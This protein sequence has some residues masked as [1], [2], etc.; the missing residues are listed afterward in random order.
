MKKTLLNLVIFLSLAKIGYAQ[1][2]KFIKGS[3]D[4]LGNRIGFHIQFLDSRFLVCD[5]NNA[6]YKQ[7]VYFINDKPLKY[8]ALPP[9]FIKH[10][11]LNGP[12][13][14]NAK[15]SI[16]LLD[17]WYSFSHKRKADSLEFLYKDGYLLYEKLVTRN[18]KPTILIPSFK[19][20][21]NYEYY[22]EERFFNKWFDDQFPSYYFQCFI[23]PENKKP[24]NKEMLYIYYDG[25]KWQE[26]SDKQ[27]E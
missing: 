26:V 27:T 17:G 21:P 8:Y 3:I 25:N 2:E 7:Y 14:K 19:A 1:S 4:S 23:K 13:V 16:M 18:N 10:Y 5:S 20:I 9:K 11:T 12:T 24:K 22:I 6:F 15:D